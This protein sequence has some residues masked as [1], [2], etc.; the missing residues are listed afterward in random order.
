M[1]IYDNATSVLTQLMQL[2]IRLAYV[3]AANKIQ[4]TKT[5][6]KNKK[7]GKPSQQGVQSYICC[8]ECMSQTHYQYLL[9]NVWRLGHDG[10]FPQQLRLQS[11][12]DL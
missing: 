7:T 4:K 10:P 5:K 9:I 1:Q 12:K 11:R 3:A 8:T 6:K 2:L